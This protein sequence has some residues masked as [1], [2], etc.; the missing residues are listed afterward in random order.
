MALTSQAASKKDGKKKKE[1]D[2]LEAKT[3]IIE[4]LIQGL[5]KDHMK[6]LRPILSSEPLALSSKRKLVSQDLALQPWLNQQKA[7]Y[8]VW[9][10]RLDLQL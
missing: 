1:K 8:D 2:K 5:G 9:C 4:V 6:Q 7:S 3:G 10:L